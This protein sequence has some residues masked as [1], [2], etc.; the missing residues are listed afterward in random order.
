[1]SEVVPETNIIRINLF[2]ISLLSI[3][4]PA[5]SF[6][7]HRFQ[8]G[9]IFEDH[10]DVHMEEHGQGDKKDEAKDKRNYA[11]DC[12]DVSESSSPNDV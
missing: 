8:S 5:S 7:D 1:M 11:I 9:G 6:P 10:I 3:C 4:V 2:K 12:M